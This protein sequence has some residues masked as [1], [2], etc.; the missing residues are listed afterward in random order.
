MRRGVTSRVKEWIVP[1]VLVWTSGVLYPQIWGPL[2]RR[3]VE[4]LE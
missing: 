3:D 2:Y 1:H 4:L